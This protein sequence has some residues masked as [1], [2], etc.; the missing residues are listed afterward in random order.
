MML[1]VPIAILLVLVPSWSV[2]L[3]PRSSRDEP[4]VEKVMARIA[5][6]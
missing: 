5:A 3:M 2:T 1:I 6:W 4:E